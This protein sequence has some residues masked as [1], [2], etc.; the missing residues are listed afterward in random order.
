[1]ADSGIL[2]AQ[3][4]KTDSVSKNTT[5]P[6]SFP[7]SFNASCLSVVGIICS[8]STGASTAQIPFIMACDK[9]GFSFKLHDTRGGEVGKYPIYYMAAGV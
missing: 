2:T 1:M 8:S 7:M 4:G 3:G 9:A 6:V 5:T